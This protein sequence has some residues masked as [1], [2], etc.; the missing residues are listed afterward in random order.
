MMAD[1]MLGGKSKG[2]KASAGGKNKT[3]KAAS[4]AKSA[5]D[6]EWQTD[7]DD[8]SD[9]QDEQSKGFYAQNKNK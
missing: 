4:K 6:E 5:G 2:T 9:D 1:M 7:S 8:E 3:K